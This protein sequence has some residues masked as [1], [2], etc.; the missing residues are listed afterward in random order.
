MKGPTANSGVLLLV[1]VVDCIAMDTV[2]DC[3]AMNTVVD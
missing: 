2:V 3:I 1:V